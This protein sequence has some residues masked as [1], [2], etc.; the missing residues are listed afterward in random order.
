ME[1]RVAYHGK[2]PCNEKGCVVPR[3]KWIENEDAQGE[4]KDLYDQA[5]ADR[6]RVPPIYRAFSLRP[7]LLRC[8]ADLAQRG[9]FEDGF[10]PRRIKEM[11][12]TYVSSLNRCPY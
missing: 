8:I 12:A 7:D 4:L 11:I 3:L 10:L 6:G 9:H 5:I 2:N 1:L